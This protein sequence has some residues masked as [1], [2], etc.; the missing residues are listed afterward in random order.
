MIPKAIILGSGS[1]ACRHSRILSDFGFDVFCVSKRLV[2]LAEIYHPHQFEALI[3]LEE[4]VRRY[5]VDH[6]D[7]FVLAGNTSDRERDWY[8]LIQLGVDEN[9][10]FCEKPGFVTSRQLNLLYNLE[11]LPVFHEGLGRLLTLVHCANASLWKSDRHW[12]VR[13]VFQRRLGGGVLPTHSHELIHLHR[14]TG[15]PPELKVLSSKSMRDVNG[16]NIHTRIEAVAEHVSIELDLLEETPL[17]YWEWE[18]AILHFYGELPSAVR[19]K[20]KKVIGV[21]QGLIDFSYQNMWTE[22]I[23]NRVLKFSDQWLVNYDC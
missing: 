23:S 1:I 15:S 17:R 19:I 14:T 10:I 4:F 12:S 22:I 5:P 6:Y 20:K 11:Y 18:N 3:E 16:E 8:R 13:Y 7:V 9:K 21:T 2:S